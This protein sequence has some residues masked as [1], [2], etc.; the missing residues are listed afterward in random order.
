[1]DLHILD[2]CSTAEPIDA[3][4]HQSSVM[5]L[6]TRE[7]TGMFIPLTCAAVQHIILSVVTGPLLTKPLAIIQV[8]CVHV[9]WFS[10]SFM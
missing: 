2:K 4:E 8:L 7:I 10:S 9:F 5:L 1:M 3:A 6:T